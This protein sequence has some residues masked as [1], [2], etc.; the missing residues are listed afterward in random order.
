MVK[1]ITLSAEE[2]LVKEARE[3]AVREGT[4]LNNFFRQW[5]KQLVGS[6]I[7][8]GEY[9]ELMRTL[10]YAEPGRKFSRDEINER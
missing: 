1:N 6:D 7:K 2:E 8:P 5:L 4:T 9:E 10:S 3:K